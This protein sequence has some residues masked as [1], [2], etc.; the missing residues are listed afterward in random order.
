MG[1]NFP[2]ARVIGVDL[3]RIQPVW[4][5]PNVEFFVDDVEDEWVQLSDFDYVHIRVVLS[6][7]KD[8]RRV[9]TTAFE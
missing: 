4:L 7:L 6:T 1:D 2:S 8:P 3:S 9:L 5:P